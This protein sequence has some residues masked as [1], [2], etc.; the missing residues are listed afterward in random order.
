M[1]DTL[2]IYV[3]IVHSL[4][5]VSKNFR[6]INDEKYVII[7][8]DLFERFIRSKTILLNPNRP[9]HIINISINDNKKLRWK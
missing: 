8:V 9:V 6:L 1:S 4:L 3:V 2:C 5:M 7:I